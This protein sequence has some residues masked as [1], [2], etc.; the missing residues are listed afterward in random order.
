[1]LKD[2]Q[3]Q[4][5][6]ERESLAAEAGLRLLRLQVLTLFRSFGSGSVGWPGVLGFVPAGVGKAIFEH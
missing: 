1:M 3:D 2:L 6:D 5:A 4:R